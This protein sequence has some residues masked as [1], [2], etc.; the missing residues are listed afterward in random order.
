MDD[1]C[2]GTY[3]TVCTSV[4]T[5]S[6]TYSTVCTSV[7]TVESKARHR[8]E[9][10]SCLGS[11]VPRRSRGLVALF[12]DAHVALFPDAHVGGRTWGSG[13]EAIS[14]VRVNQ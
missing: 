11:L 7:H 4:H 8:Q 3:S 5:C 2:S 14:G 9:H 13:N 12:P 6:G 1:G 10:W